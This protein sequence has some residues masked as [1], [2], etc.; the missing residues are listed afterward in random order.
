MLGR[1]R[2]AH[3]PAA[4]GEPADGPTSADGPDVDGANTGSPNTGNTNT[5]GPRTGGPDAGGAEQ[6]SRVIPTQVD[7]TARAASGLIGGPWGRHAVI[8]RQWFW[9]PLRVILALAILMLALGWIQKS[10][11]QS[12]NWALSQPVAD[13]H[14]KL[15]YI[16]GKEYV[17]LCYSDIIPL[18]GVEGLA[19]GQVPYKD[20]AVEYPVLTGYFMYAAATVARQYDSLADGV[21]GLPHPP[22]VQTYYEVTALMLSICLLVTVWAVAR[23]ARRRVWDAA[24]VALA[25]LV[26]VQGFTNWDLFA[27]MFATTGMLAWARRRHALAGVLLGL[28]AAAKLY[29]LFLLG[30]LFVLCLRA[31]KMREFGRALAG[32]VIAWSV[33]NVPVAVLWT[34]SWERFFTLNR[35]RPADPDTLWRVGETLTG[36]QIDPSVLNVGVGVAFLLV[37]IGVAYLAWAAPRRPRVAQLAF[38]LVAGFLLTNKVWSPQ[39]SLWLVPLAV[40]ARPSWR[41]FLTWQAIDAFLWFP[42][43]YWFLKTRMQS[44]QN[45]DGYH[46]LV[47]G[48]DEGW[49]HLVVVFRDAAVVLYCIMVIRDILRPD[50]DPVRVDGDDDPA[51]GV[52][53]RA[54]ERP[55]AAEEPEA[56]PV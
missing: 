11:C 34:Q 44:Y 3:R 36:S 10:P 41:I 55:Q 17:R 14:G 22:P 31:G 26:A 13:S 4:D 42:R 30:P 9:T 1:D 52:L 54:D 28:G 27:V 51:G 46:V 50:K 19:Q 15:V 2:D 39:Y 32:A 48:I 20:H 21:P 45:V 8:G 29:P 56:V 25:P 53:D 18:Y 33:V 24:M 47:R 43:M 6:L 40:L 7:P 12:G 38:L 16:T 5:G 49:F 35:T 37:C 23:I